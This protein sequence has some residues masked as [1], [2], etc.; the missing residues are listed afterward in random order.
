MAIFRIL[1]FIPTCQP[2][3]RAAASI[4][5]TITCQHVLEGLRK[6]LT[7]DPLLQVLNKSDGSTK[8]SSAERIVAHVKFLSSGIH[9]TLC[10]LVS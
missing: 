9:K 6:F 8:G 3:E 10:V 1:I 2:G 5:S 4:I 7:E